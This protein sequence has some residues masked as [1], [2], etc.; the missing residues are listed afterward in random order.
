MQSKSGYGIVLGGAILVFAALNISL[1]LNVGAL[2][3]PPVYDDNGYL[4]DGYYRFMFDGVRSFRSLAENFVQHPPHAPVETLT[5]I[6]GFWLFGS[7][8]IGPY[9]MNFWGF[10]AFAVMMFSVAH[11]RIDARSATFLAITAMFVPAAGAIMSELRPDMIAGLFFAYSGYV[12][13]VR[14]GAR[15]D[16]RSAALVGL[17]CAFSLIIKLS[18]VV[19]T[20]P[21]LGLALVAGAVLQREFRSQAISRAAITVATTLVIL[22][23]VTYIWGSQTYAYIYQAL[24]S[25]RD[26]WFTPGDRWFH[27]N[28]YA[29]GQ[30][31]SIGLGNLFYIAVALVLFD[32]AV[33]LATKRG[34]LRSF[35]YY[36][37]SLL[38]FIGIANSA[39]KTVYQ[40]SFFFFPLVIS[41]VL[42]LSRLLATI[43]RRAFGL[44]GAVTL[45]AVV[46]LEPAHTY[47][48]G[49]YR[50]DTWPMLEQISDLVVQGTSVAPICSGPF[51]R[52]A[53]VGSYPVTAQA[54]ALEVAKQDHLRLAIDQL[55]IMREL[56][57]MMQEIE[58]ANFVLLPNEAGMREA[59]NQHLP[60]VEF[61]DQIMGLL[62][63]DSR[64]RE[65]RIDATDPP[66][67]FVREVCEQAG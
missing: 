55:F 29:M 17:L 11:D 20:V 21:M 19:I 31:G 7:S 45:L 62:R 40:G 41:A 28:Y 9:I 57:P 52:Y 1:A 44:A 36:A 24:I 60:G 37:W 3:A 43:P 59:V 10:T 54:V 14:D 22:V 5:V 65:Y 56:E 2:S 8:N 15:R 46:F 6:L 53:T 34:D 25:N 48:Q 47:Q 23:P 58:K 63:Q 35:A 67:L 51:Y 64:W 13:L 26:V 16:R 12:L 42:A 50:K 39:E 49:V 33:S 18:A 4:L 61:S 38:I 30:G 66:T 32:V 27:L